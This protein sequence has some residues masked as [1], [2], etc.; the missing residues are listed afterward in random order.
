MTRIRRAVEQDWPAIEGLLKATG[1]PVAGASRHLDTFVV[2]VDGPQVVA[3]A[4]LEVHGDAGL[5]RSVAVTPERHGQGVG[6][7]VVDAVLADAT[8]RGLRTLHLLTT[9]AADYFERRG[10]TRQPRLAAPPALAGSEEF[11]G[12]CPA[13]ATLMALALPTI[14]P[15]ADSAIRMATASDAEAVADI[16]APIVRDTA[17]SFELHSPTVDEMRT[18]IVSTLQTLPWLVSLD[19]HGSVDGYVYASKHRERP[20]YQWSVDVTAYVREDARG[21]GV[22]KRLY[23][24]LFDELVR[25][26]YFQAFAGIALPN[27]PSVALHESL[28]FELLGIYRKVGF[29]NGAW[30]DVGWW[31]KELRAPPSEPQKPMSF[32]PSR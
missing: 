5:L 4:G 21:Q 7:L 31:Q 3:T 24:R 8:S 23:L 11:R 16:Y 15:A 13:S 9:T 6:G 20:A 1:L 28:G 2:A 25:L 26:G 14:P 27:A 17:I 29:K 30:R 18:R 32:S 12:A 19:Q 22:G 10:F